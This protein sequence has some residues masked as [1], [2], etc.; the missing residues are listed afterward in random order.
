MVLKGPPPFNNESINVLQI[1]YKRLK[2]VQ[3]FKSPTN[4]I[5]LNI[6]TCMYCR[7]RGR[8][9][10]AMQWSVWYIYIIPTYVV[11]T[12]LVRTDVTLFRHHVLCCPVVR[13]RFG[14]LKRQDFGTLTSNWD[15][16]TS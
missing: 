4:V 8:Q 13:T 3:T 1:S 12:I 7:D 9:D 11:C 10:N 5:K 16:R 15:D 14:M 2:N 6:G